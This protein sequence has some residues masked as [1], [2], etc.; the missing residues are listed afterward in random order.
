MNSKCWIYTGDGK[1]PI[2]WMIRNRKYD[3]IK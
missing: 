2:N 3:E 1:I